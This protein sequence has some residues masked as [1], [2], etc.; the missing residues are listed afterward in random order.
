MIDIHCHILPGIDDGAKDMDEALAL[1]NLAV[2][3]GVTQIVVTPHLHF[4]RFYNYLSVIQSSFIDL[5][6][7]VDEA[8][9][10]IE[11]AYAAEVRLDSEI[12]SLLANQQLPLYGRYNNQE[13]MLL[14]FPHSH[15]PAGSDILVKHLLKKNIT[16]VIAHPERNRDLLKSPDK[17]KPFVRLGCWFQVTASSITGHFG[18]ECQALALSYIEQGFIHI[19]ASDAHNLKRRPPV[20]S[21]ARS[22]ITAIFGEDKVKQLFYDNPYNITTSLFER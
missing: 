13:F 20:L 17:I 22:K 5:Q 8:K 3:D 1:I 15:I 2:E 7:A 21:E 18:E 12:L 6:Q 9:I 11:L 4:G 10:Q 19:V 14:E 16:P